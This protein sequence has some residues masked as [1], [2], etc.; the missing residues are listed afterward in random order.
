MG[1]LTDSESWLG[2]SQGEEWV[3]VWEAGDRRPPS[4][5]QAQHRST[6]FEDVPCW[7][8]GLVTAGGSWPR[9]PGPYVHKAKPMSY[10]I[11]LP[12]FPRPPTWTEGEQPITRWTE[13]HPGLGGLWGHCRGWKV[14]L[15]EPSW[16]GRT[17]R[18]FHQRP[19][20]VSLIWFV[21]FPQDST[22]VRLSNF[23][24]F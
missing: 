9:R 12:S 17:E 21:V 18:A 14:F 4:P 2:M 16:A 1:K 10:F 24:Q 23:T 7:V 11:R 22:H 6:G 3:H 19:S 8:T 15:A 20:V 5:Q 13:M